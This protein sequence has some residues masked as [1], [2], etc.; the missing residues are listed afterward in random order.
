MNRKILNNFYSFLENNASLLLVLLTILILIE[1]FI[2]GKFSVF[3]MHDFAGDIFPRYISLW[4]NFSLHGFSYWDPNIGGGHDR[5]SNLVYYDNIPSIL[6]SILPSWLAFQIYIISTTT[7]GIY[8]FYKYMISNFNAE[9]TMV[10]IPIVIF[11]I[12]T[13]YLN[14][15]G[16]V[17]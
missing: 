7:L 17:A 9:K 10:I 4:K 5:L 3:H 8:G 11:P 16:L 6:I 15:T 12:I 13:A 2:L 1:Y 14:S